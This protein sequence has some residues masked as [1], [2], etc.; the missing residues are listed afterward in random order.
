MS[1]AL[2]LKAQRQ[3]KKIISFRNCTVEMS[4][5]HHKLK[6]RL[7]WRAKN[8]I[9]KSQNWMN[10]G[11][12]TVWVLSNEDQNFT[13]LLTFFFALYFAYWFF[14]NYYAYFCQKVSIDW[15]SSD[16]F[17]INHKLSSSASHSEF[18]IFMESHWHHDE[19][20]NFNFHTS[21]N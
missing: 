5:E 14:R 12:H 21:F 15:H 4:F 2:I 11:P 17:R 10:H 18:Y 20:F 8:E 3:K 9:R 19:I 6:K 16:L 13:F 1:C 7:N